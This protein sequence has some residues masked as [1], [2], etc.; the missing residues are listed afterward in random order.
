MTIEGKTYLVKGD[1]TARTLTT[2]ADDVECP[3]LSPDGTRI[4]FKKVTA[5]AGPTAHWTPAIM[6]LSTGE[7]QLLLETRT[8]DDQI[9]WL[10]DETILYGMPRDGAP[11]DTDVWALGVDGSEPELFIAHAWSPSV[12]RR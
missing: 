5:G 7:V 4:A 10:D 3:S 11:G 1:L 2:V 9:E 12:V 8:V 6:D